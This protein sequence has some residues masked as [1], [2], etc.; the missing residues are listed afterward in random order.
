METEADRLAYTVAS[1]AAVIDPEL[2][3]LG[4]GMGTAADLLLEPIDRALRAFTPLVPKVVQG[5]LGEDAVLTGAI[6]VGL[7]AAEGLV[8]DRQWARPDY[9]AVR[10]TWAVDAKSARQSG[11]PP[12]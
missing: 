2:I 11:R 10:G 9:R 6:S 12:R 3:V 5:E 4:G 8:F 7:R 1:V